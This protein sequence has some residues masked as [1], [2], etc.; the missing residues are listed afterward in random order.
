MILLLH[1][2]TGEYLELNNSVEYTCSVAIQTRKCHFSGVCKNC[3]WYAFEKDNPEYL[4]Y[5]KDIDV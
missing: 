5:H 1:I 3:V 4:W 2:E